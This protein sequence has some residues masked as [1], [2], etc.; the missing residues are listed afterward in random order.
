MHRVCQ[1]S[2]H[3]HDECPNTP[4]ARKNEWH[5]PLVR[6]VLAAKP[7]AGAEYGWRDVHADLEKGIY[8]GCYGWD[9][10]AY[11]GIAEKKAGV[12][13]KEWYKKRTD[14]EFYLPSFK[15][16]TDNPETRKQWEGIATFDPLGM[17]AHP[18]TIAACKAKLN[19]EELNHLPIGDPYGIVTK[20]GVQTQK[21]AILYSWN[22][23]RLAEKLDLTEADLRD[24]LFK[25]SNNP[26]LKDPNIRTYIPAVGGCTIYSFG[27]VR[28]LRDSKTEVAVRVHDECIGSD[29]FG[30]DICTCR[31]YLIFALEQCIMTAQRGGVGIVVYFRKEGRSLGE[32]VKFRVYN[33]RENQKGGDK[34]DQYFHQTESIAGI[35]DARFQTMMPD[36]LLW[37][38]LKRIDWLHSMSNEKYEAIVGAGIQVMQ[39]V[40]LPDDY[41]KENMRVEIDAKVMSG[42]KSD[43]FEKNV[44]VAAAMSA[45]SIRSQCKRIYDLALKDALFHFSVNNAK[46]SDAVDV[47]EKT[48]QE[49]YPTLEIPY[50]SRFRHFDSVRLN[51]IVDSWKCPVLE[52]V[53]RLLDLA[54][55]SVLLDAGAGSDWSYRS[56]GKTQRSSE[57]LATASL[58]MFVDGFFSSDLAYPYRANSHA[59]KKI[60]GADL[61]R[62]FQVDEQNP[63]LAIEGRT[64]LMN[65]LG[66]AL[67]KFPQYFGDE[68]PRP[69]NVVDY[70]LE[71]REGDTVDVKHIW[72]CFVTSFEMVW[73]KHATGISHGDVWSHSKLQV[74]GEPGSDLVPFHKLT[75]WLMY[76][77]IEPIET[78]LK[79]RVVNVEETMTPLAEYRNGGLLI[80]CGVLTPKDPEYAFGMEHAVGSELI[81]EWRALTVV[82]ID[83]IATELRKRFNRTADTLPLSRVL[84]GGTWRA[85]RLMAKR[86]RPKTRAP[87]IRIASD[88]SVF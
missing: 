44:V 1:L 69:G 34:A 31:P 15:E 29:V 85:G 35:R 47:V 32:V 51:H 19:I 11:W 33:A 40:T 6:K 9:N 41:V 57:G 14:D 76:T 77:I 86:L 79:I 60:T 83:A 88:G 64:N 4:R 36:A 55:V 56:H 8:S 38:G 52:K 23:P 73:P 48:I 7:V 87:P 65:R 3:F 27:D 54:T 59:L 84:E 78:Y 24:A 62:A 45:A 42:Y 16:L 75:Q 13:L 71:K 18:P 5:A 50:H 53:R 39:R 68:G 2:K 63:L 74:V 70:L 61:K 80:D 43:S 21:A 30:S 82:Y 12:D 67:D 58:D 49:F 72:D 10:A 37:L 28:K 25:F 26:T 81:T 22:L 20:D 17:Y 66:E 46:L